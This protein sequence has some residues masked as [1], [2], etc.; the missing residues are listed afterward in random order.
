MNT[1]DDSS[2]GSIGEA[3]QILFE[4]GSKCLPTFVGRQQSILVATL[5]VL[6]VFIV[7]VVPILEERK[8]KEEEVDPLK[9][10]RWMVFMCGL[11]LLC[12][13]SHGFIADRVYMFAMYKYNKQHYANVYWLKHYMG[14]LKQKGLSI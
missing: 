10:S 3:I 12:A 1:V 9:R 11:L 4:E 2:I 6:V 14:A 13:L 7:G 5:I 8:R